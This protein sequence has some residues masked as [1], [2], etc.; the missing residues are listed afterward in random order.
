[1]INENFIKNWIPN[2]KSKYEIAYENIY[3]KR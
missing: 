3:I 1:M 2:K